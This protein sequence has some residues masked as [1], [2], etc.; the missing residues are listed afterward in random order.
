[1]TKPSNP[2]I[3]QMLLLHQNKEM[4]PFKGNHRLTAFTP[5]TDSVRTSPVS[6]SIPSSWGQS[7]PTR[8]YSSSCKAGAG[9]VWPGKQEGRELLGEFTLRLERKVCK[10]C[11]SQVAKEDTVHLEHHRKLS[12]D[13]EDSQC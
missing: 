3:L 6:S 13:N 10:A 7:R 4:G 8:S 9:S 5:L 12:H 1:M 2:E 11:L